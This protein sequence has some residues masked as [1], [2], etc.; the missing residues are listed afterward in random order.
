VYLDENEQQEEAR[1]TL[2]K[3][4][5][6]VIREPGNY[7][8]EDADVHED[9]FVVKFAGLDVDVVFVPLDPKT[10]LIKKG[11]GG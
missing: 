3:A 4:A 11:Y 2:K 6:R 9:G 8:V 7:I 10:E 5:L 1:Q